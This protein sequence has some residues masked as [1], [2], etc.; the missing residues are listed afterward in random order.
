MTT[1]PVGT[2]VDA[3]TAKRIE[4]VL[5][6]QNAGRSRATT[7]RAYWDGRHSLLERF[8][9]GSGTR[10]ARSVVEAARGLLGVPGAMNPY[11]IDLRQRIVA[12]HQKGEGSVRELARR[13]AVAPNTVQN[14]LNLE[15][16]TGSVAP[17]PHG[18]GPAPK[19]DDAGVQQVRALLQE[20]ND[21]TLDELRQQLVARHQVQV[22]RTTTW[23]AVARAG[24]TR[25][26]RRYVPANRIG[27]TCKGSGRASSDRCSKRIR[28]D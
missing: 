24:M 21:Q 25:K 17:R 19:I 26:K 15:R 6:N 28:T 3:V 13:F 14:Y 8:P 27:P 2:R 20:K 16:T 4:T 23:R 11:S 1:T 9:G 5:A 22:S 7:M 10:R 18:G 12:A